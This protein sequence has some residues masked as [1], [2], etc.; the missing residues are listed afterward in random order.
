MVGSAVGPERG[1]WATMESTV[2]VNNEDRKVFAVGHRRH[3]KVHTY[4]ATAGS[5]QRGKV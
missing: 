2:Q 5:T 3:G 4:V 1:D